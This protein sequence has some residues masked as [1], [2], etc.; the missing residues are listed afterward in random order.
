MFANF[1]TALPSGAAMTF[2]ILFGMQALISMQPG[3]AVKA[4]VHEF[5]PWIYQP[6]DEKI[7]E[8][9]FRPDNIPDV[10]PT[11][12]INPGHDE[13]GDGPA[14]HIPFETPTPRADNHDFS[15]FGVRDGPLVAVVRVQP[16][17]PS[18]MSSKG[19][20]GFV[21]VIFDVL[22]DG[23]VSNIAVLESSHRGFERSA[24]QA[25]SRFKFKARVVDGIPQPSRGIRYRFTFEMD[26]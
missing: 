24:M 23:S 17:Y 2:L 7:F 3:A 11:P 22:P 13:T 8:E 5:T 12:P 25:A 10:V 18:I 14:L 19:I 21:T 6:R 1:V 9:S 4:D 26:Q 15:K 16:T 20:E